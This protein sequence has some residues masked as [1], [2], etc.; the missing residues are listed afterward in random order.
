MERLLLSEVFLNSD[1]AHIC[2]IAFA[3][4]IAT[5][6]TLQ[7]PILQIFASLI[8]FFL[9]QK[10]EEKREKSLSNVFLQ[11]SVDISLNSITSR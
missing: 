11:T 5:F 4:G 8:L 1:Y 3:S 10:R 6:A 9:F 2:F 7:T